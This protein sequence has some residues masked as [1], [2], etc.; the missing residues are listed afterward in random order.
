MRL[1][2]RIKIKTPES[3]ELEFTLA[4]IGNRGVALIM[5]YLVWN[6]L[7][8]GVLLL[9]ALIAFQLQDYFADIENLQLWLTGIALLIVFVVYTCY[10]VFFET[11]WQGQTPGKRYAKIRVVRDN[12][13]P[14]GLTQALLRSL[15]RTVDDLLFLGMLCIIFGRQEKR[16]GDWAAGTIVIQEDRPVSPAEIQLSEQAQSLA[17]QLLR[18]NNINAL[19]PD[20]F[21]V[22]R[23]YLQRRVVMDDRA[24][25]TVSRQLAEQVSQLIELNQIPFEMSPELLL[26]GIY[27]AYQQQNS[28]S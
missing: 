24:K 18:E 21:A 23:E 10:F 19:M 3:V 26:E 4:G 9:W 2:N 5:D 25:A 20:D 1:F 12:G 17:A 14:V 15:L 22:I 13:Q 7:L 6:V 16:L 8:I 28:I 11:L 27:L